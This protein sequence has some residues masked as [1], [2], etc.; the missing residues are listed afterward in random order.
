MGVD[1][2]GDVHGD[3]LRPWMHGCH[4]NNAF[5]ALQDSASPFVAGAFGGCN[6]KT[7]TIVSS[8]LLI[9]AS[10]VALAQQTA[11]CPPLPPTAGLHWE[12]QAQADFIV[13]KAI[14]DDGRAVLNMMLS[15]RDPDLALSRALR[16]EKGTF[17]GESLY[18]YKLD[19]GGRPMPGIESR[20]ITSVKL[21]KKRYAQIW[22]DAADNVELRVMQTLT[23]NMNL[24]PAAA[25]AGSN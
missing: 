3:A 25:L 18:W 7:A 12:Q 15:N 1:A 22:I 4:S 23:Q 20:R 5:R 9:V 17:A 6:V 16:A 19:L 24:N 14:T 21:D 13:C 2:H 11:D 8:L 10:P